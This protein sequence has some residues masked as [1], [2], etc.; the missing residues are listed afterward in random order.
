M[1]D[2]RLWEMALSPALVSA[3]SAM[4]S[5]QLFKALKP[6]ARGRL[7][8]LRKIVDY[9]GWPSS[10]TAFIVACAVAVGIVEG[11]RSSLFAAVAVVASILVYDILKMRRVVDLDGREID[12]LLARSGMGRSERPPQ[13]KGHSKAEVAWGAVW[14]CAWAIAVCALW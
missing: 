2:Y 7:P 13:F 3:V 4:A 9:G 12:R 1:K 6:L 14:G 10:H 8:D 5:S 11:F